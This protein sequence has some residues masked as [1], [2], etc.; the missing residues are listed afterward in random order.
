LCCEAGKCRYQVHIGVPWYAW[1][2]LHILHCKMVLLAS[3]TACTAQNYCMYCKKYCLPGPGGVLPLRP[4]PLPLLTAT[5]L[6]V[7]GSS[8]S[9]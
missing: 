7:L 8:S 4:G 2:V 6:L 1:G 9:S 3:C 5:A